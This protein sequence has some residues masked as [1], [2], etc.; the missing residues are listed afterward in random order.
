MIVIL[1]LVLMYGNHLLSFYVDYT[2]FRT[3]FCR[4]NEC[5][6]RYYYD[7]SSIDQITA[8]DC[9]RCNQTLFDHL[10]LPANFRESR[11]TL[12]KFY[13]VFFTIESVC[14]LA[15]AIAFG[16]RQRRLTK[17]CLAYLILS[18]FGFFTA[19]IVFDNPLLTS[20]LLI[21][22]YSNFFLFSR[23]YLIVSSFDSLNKVGYKSKAYRKIKIKFFNF[24]SWFHQKDL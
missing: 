11:K 21:L 22:N 14:Y 2:H 15:M 3:S 18:L 23:L 13:S 12:L 1:C 16:F 24:F 19:G 10:I 5:I 4:G 17:I 7:E 6:K 9:V 20:H 8:K